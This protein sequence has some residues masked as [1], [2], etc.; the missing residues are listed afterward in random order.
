MSITVLVGL[1]F[2]IIAIKLVMTL[3]SR[4]SILVIGG[5]Y[6][7]A[8]DLVARDTIETHKVT[9]MRLT[10]RILSKVSIAILCLQGFYPEIRPQ[11]VTGHF[12]NK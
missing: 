7:T 6:N 10:I 3:E 2:S 5:L 4:Q 12:S 9:L 8:A 1:F 11:L